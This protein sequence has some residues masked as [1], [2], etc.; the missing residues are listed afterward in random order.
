MSQSIICGHLSV[1]VIAKPISCGDLSVVGIYQP[2]RSVAFI[3]FST[4]D[5]LPISFVDAVRDGGVMKACD[6]SMQHELLTVP[7]FV[8]GAGLFSPPLPCG[9]TKIP[10]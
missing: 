7:S 4:R 1:V 3:F 6:W 2:I 9:V 8:V 5:L 10:S